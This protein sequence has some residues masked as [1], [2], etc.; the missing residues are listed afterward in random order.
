MPLVFSQV[1]GLAVHIL[2]LLI[3]CVRVVMLASGTR[4][5]IRVLVQQRRLSIQVVAVLGRCLSQFIQI[6]LLLYLSC[7]ALMMALR[8]DAADS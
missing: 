2:V 3:M 4:N 8:V 5:G 7:F 1:Y 6:G